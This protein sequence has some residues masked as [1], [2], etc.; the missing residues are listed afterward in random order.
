MSPAFK[1]VNRG[2]DN[3]RWEEVRPLRVTSEQQ[4][5]ELKRWGRKTSKQDSWVYHLI[6]LFIH[7]TIWRRKEGGREGRREGGKERGRE[8]GREEE[9]D[10]V[11]ISH[12]FRNRGCTHSHIMRYSPLVDWSTR[13]PR[14]HWEGC[15]RFLHASWTDNLSQAYPQEKVVCLR[16]IQTNATRPLSP[17]PPSPY[18]KRLPLSAETNSPSSYLLSA[19]TTV[20]TQLS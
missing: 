10:F 5:L 4:S 3:T 18:A 1:E 12:C 13:S 14:K 9:R 20:C 15:P 2:A 11:Q 6:D 16:N 19:A 8:R 17:I 7:L